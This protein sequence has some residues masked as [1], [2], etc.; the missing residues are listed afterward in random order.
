[1][2]QKQGTSKLFGT[3][4][5]WSMTLHTLVD[6][7]SNLGCLRC[8]REVSQR[9]PLRSALEICNKNQRTSYQSW[10]F[11][12]SLSLSFKSNH[13]E[14]G[15]NTRFLLVILNDVSDWMI[16]R[17]S[18]ILVFAFMYLVEC[19]RREEGMGTFRNRAI[20]IIIS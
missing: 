4:R 3:T 5:V 10:D 19:P 13:L 20:L 14:F 17:M 15:K 9:V 16:I 8:R 11:A 18:D 2:S 7:R 12:T 1:M 6:V